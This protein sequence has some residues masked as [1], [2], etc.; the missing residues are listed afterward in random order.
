MRCICKSLI[1]HLRAVPFL[2]LMLVASLNISRDDQLEFGGRKN[3]FD[4][5]PD[6]RLR[7]QDFLFV[8]NVETRSNNIIEKL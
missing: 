7:H 5:F 4:K 6:I 8:K 3:V 1:D 2:D